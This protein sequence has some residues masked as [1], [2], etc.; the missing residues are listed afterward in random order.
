MA[1]TIITADNF[2]AFT[3][4]GPAIVEFWAPW[5]TYCRRL[6]GIIDKLS[7]AYEGKIAIG[8]VNIDDHPSLAERFTIDTIPTLLLF[9]NGKEGKPI[10]APGSKADIEAWLAEQGAI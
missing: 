6:T 9:Q 10:V 7:T 1:A 4:Q 5:C 8:Q 3:T 2:E